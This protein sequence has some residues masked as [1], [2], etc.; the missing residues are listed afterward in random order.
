MLK[1]TSAP[2]AVK[3]RI[4]ILSALTHPKVIRPSINEVAT[5]CGV[6]R[7]FVN[8]TVA[9]WNSDGL[10]GLYDRGNRGRRKT[11]DMGE[12]AFAMEDASSK[13]PPSKRQ[14][15][16]NVA[17]RF[18]LSKSTTSDRLIDFGV[19]GRGHVERQFCPTEMFDVHIVDFVGL[20]IN[21]PNSAFALCVDDATGD[22]PRSRPWDDDGKLAFSIGKATVG[23]ERTETG[24]RAEVAFRG[25]LHAALD[26]GNGGG[27]VALKQRRHHKGFL[28]FLSE[29]EAGVPAALSIHVFTGEYRPT[30]QRRIVY[31]LDRHPRIHV[32][33]VGTHEKWLKQISRWHRFLMRAHVRGVAQ[34]SPAS[35]SSKIESIFRTHEMRRPFVW[36]A[37]HGAILLKWKQAPRK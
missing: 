31:W 16:R 32:H 28:R 21:P 7:Q 24:A 15:A 10:V 23:G 27:S 35:F 2:K 19:W 30:T 1:S 20:Y 25:P 26:L 5:E 17:E 4:E 18:G 11:R 3:K 6:P 13:L 9:R 29:L 8:R 36:V 14:T 37:E 33:E 34:V 22:D 12:I